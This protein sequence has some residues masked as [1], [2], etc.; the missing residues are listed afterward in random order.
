MY[1]IWGRYFSSLPPPPPSQHVISCKNW[2][3]YHYTHIHSH[4]TE[5]RLR[6][7]EDSE[8]IFLTFLILGSAAQPWN[9]WGS[10]AR[11]RVNIKES[12]MSFSGQYRINSSFKSTRLPNAPPD[13][14]ISVFQNKH[15]VPLCQT[16]SL[17]G[18]CAQADQSAELS[19]PSLSPK[20][21]VHAIGEQDQCTAPCPLWS[22]GHHRTCAWRK[23]G[24]GFNAG[25][26]FSVGAI[27]QICWTMIFPSKPWHGCS[28]ELSILG[29]QSLPTPLSAL[30]HVQPTLSEDCYLTLCA[31]GTK[32]FN[33]DLTTSLP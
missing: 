32:C 15:E 31:S 23:T 30:M 24:G 16:L 22:H 1:S 18:T 13:F 2:R 10:A 29:T 6:E 14:T 26:C 20:G 9:D 28:V 4:L 11:R 21:N 7:L 25:V 19:L 5:P 17:L 12:E 3:P 33:F 27:K 8:I